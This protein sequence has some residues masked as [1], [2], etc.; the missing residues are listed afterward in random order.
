[1]IKIISLPQQ[2]EKEVVKKDGKDQY[3]L[4]SRSFRLI[5]NKEKK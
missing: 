5:I 4:Q 1:V 3:N 2:A